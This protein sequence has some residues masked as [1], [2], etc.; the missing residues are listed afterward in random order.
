[1]SRNYHALTTHYNVY[2]NGKESLK[3]GLKKI[4]T[5]T[6]NNYTQLLPIFE[7]QDK[8]SRA[9]SFGDMD[10]VIN[11][12]NKAIKIHSITRKPKR[13]KGN[14]TA[15]YTAFRK[16]K[17]YNN[18]IDDCYLL[19][20]EGEFY[21]KEYSKA[22]KHY[23]FILKQYP[24]SELRAAAQLGIARSFID[25]G[26]SSQGRDILARISNLANLSKNQKLEINAL[27]ASI[28]LK[29]N[30]Y[31]LCIDYLNASINI[32]KNKYQKSRFYYI[33]AQLYMEMD[34]KML[35]VQNYNA[36]IKLNP[37]Y[38]MVFNAKISSALAYSSGSEGDLIRSNL[39]NMLK[40]RKNLIFKDQIY[41]ALAEMDMVDGLQKSAIENYWESTL[42]S[43]ENDN[44]KALSFLKLGDIYFN[45][46]NY[47][48][49]QLCYDSSMV[50]LAPNYKNYKD[51]ADRVSKLTELVVNL[52]AV[53]R[54]DSL[55][56]VAKLNPSDRDKLIRTII[57][58]IT[59]KE[60]LDLQ[61]TNE[62]R[63][64]RSFYMQNNMLGNRNSSANNS[65]GGNWYFYNP[66]TVGMGKSEFKRKWGRRKL[67]DNWRRRS[68]AIVEIVDVSEDE[69]DT[70]V[71]KV[72]K[73]AGNP[74]EK[75][76]YIANLP[77][78]KEAVEESNKIIMKSLY[79][80]AIVYHEKL[81]DYSEA[82]KTLSKLIDRFPDNPYILPAYYRSYV[83]H[84]KLG[85]TRQAE[86][87]SNL[88]IKNYPNSDY[89]KALK[90]PLFYDKVENEKKKI[91]TVY[92]GIYADYQNYYYDKV[93]VDC[94]KAIA[95]HPESRLLSRFK[96]LRVLAIGK[97]QKS[98]IF[99]KELN[100]L[101]KGDLSAELKETCE[102]ILKSIK[103]GAATVVY[104]KTD[105]QIARRNKLTRN[106]R[107]DN[108]KQLVLEKV[109][110]E[111]NEEVKTKTKTNFNANIEGEQYFVIYFSEKDLDSSRL[112]FNVSTYN[113]DNYNKRTFDV[114]V[115]K[116]GGG[117]SIILVK[118]LPN[119]LDA[120]QYFTKILKSNDVYTDLKK[121]DYR[122]FIIS[123]LN[124]ATFIKSEDISSYLPFYTKAYFNVVSKPIVEKSKALKVKK[125][126]KNKIRSKDFILDVNE[127]HKF[128]LLFPS[129]KVDVVK[130]RNIIYAHDKDYSVVYNQYDEDSDIVIVD[131]IGARA[132]AIEYLLDIIKDTNVYSSLTN[133]QY[134]NFI[135]T[136]SNFNKLY[137]NKKLNV[138]MDFYVENYVDYIRKDSKP[139]PSMKSLYTINN[140]ATHYFA[141]TYE[142]KNV[143]VSALKKAI[144]SYNNEYLKLEIK[145][146]DTET[147][148]LIVK[149]MKNKK[150][151]LLY[152]R[153][154]LSNPELLSAVKEV[155]HS[156]FVISH[157]NFKLLLRDKNIPVYTYFFE[158]T[159]F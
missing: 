86:Y 150:Q 56:M 112:M 87:F 58:K 37:D 59:D 108:E 153:A 152:Y 67:E 63:N 104:T 39:K 82:V 38:T 15:K 20:A 51:I 133:V 107:F 61:A 139:K 12:A 24:K 96:F 128:V 84:T 35:A 115:V 142:K 147:N 109:L 7:Y 111:E 114:D 127:N 60:A 155:N 52:N 6:E 72:S 66:T 62:S 18:W 17:E 90:D 68:K 132:E 46:F 30:N 95:L 5:N 70:V 73:T 149:K 135:I 103:E 124:Y 21:K 41:Y 122:N 53:E 16:K 11:K 137:D 27:R 156:Y 101:L 42:L 159:Y 129:K 80:A 69:E 54:Q 4:K 151:A 120:I 105:M 116:M 55:Q 146:L 118:G 113:V 158:N 94:D 140:A 71:E 141:L 10:R 106:W 88:V 110:S 102:S 13:K 40:D 34:N 123:K 85:N 75:S 77:L 100:E 22:E 130:M 49:A 134:S 138:Y 92:E 36:L 74:K 148:I 79:M 136:Y 76:F 131:N 145:P 125:N 28:A 43:L 1:M 9:S 154:F 45:K 29:E 26:R 65:A 81:E 57:K 157:E 143:D 83:L 89:S 8:Q 14:K 99:I 23:K 93:V 126:K 3:T 78:T 44:Q 144:E 91:N 119:K 2:F 64:D 117:K 33:I 19:L 32:S 97:T 50:Y 47:N 98:E 31:Q 121:I 25:R 48:K